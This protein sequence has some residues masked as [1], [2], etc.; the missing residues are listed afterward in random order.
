MSTTVRHLDLTTHTVFLYT[1]WASIIS[2][3]CIIIFVFLI[4]YVQTRI[5]KHL[6]IYLTICVTTLLAMPIGNCFFCADYV[7]P[8]LRLP[9]PWD[10]INS[11]IIMTIG[12]HIA[13]FLVLG[14]ICERLLATVRWK[15]YEKNEKVRKILGYC[16]G[17]GVVIVSFLFGFLTNIT[18]MSL[19]DKLIIIDVIHGVTIIVSF[20]TF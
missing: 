19:E 10:F 20:Y 5:P 15:N 3:I 16:F 4:N 13:R 11:R 14:I 7:Y 1:F 9:D 12:G 18:N 17:F 8:A 6:K 2:I